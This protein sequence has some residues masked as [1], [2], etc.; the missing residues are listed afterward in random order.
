MARTDNKKP[1]VPQSS[2]FGPLELICFMKNKSCCFKGATWAEDLKPSSGVRCQ[3]TSTEEVGDIS[4]EIT[5][6]IREMDP[7]ILTNITC[8]LMSVFSQT[9]CIE[10]I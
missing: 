6:L 5:T 7:S 3:Q 9:I 8:F 1:G 2:R 10:L 4:E